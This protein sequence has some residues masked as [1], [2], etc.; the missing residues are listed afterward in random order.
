MESYRDNRR[1][2][3]IGSLFSPKRGRMNGAIDRPWCFRLVNISSCL[4]SRFR[5]PLR[6]GGV[7]EP[8]IRAPFAPIVLPL[9]GE[10]TFVNI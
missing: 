5:F 8:R 1:V 2:L 3:L 7:F 9:S 6:G 10:G 4:P